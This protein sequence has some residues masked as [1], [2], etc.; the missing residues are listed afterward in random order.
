MGLKNPPQT[1][2]TSFRHSRKPEFDIKADQIIPNYSNTYTTAPK[3]FDPKIILEQKKFL[4]PK[5]FL[6]KSFFGTNIF[7]DEIF[8]GSQI[9]FN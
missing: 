8:F 4:G 1:Y 7:F 3:F 2:W 5:I 9:M 6:T